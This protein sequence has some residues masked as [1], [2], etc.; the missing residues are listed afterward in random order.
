MRQLVLLGS[1]IAAG[2]LLAIALVMGLSA[3]I[4]WTVYLVLAP[5]AFAGLFFA[6]APWMRVAALFVP[7]IFLEHNIISLRP[8]GPLQ[9]GITLPVCLIL[10][11]SLRRFGPPLPTL[12][13]FVVLWLVFLGAAAATGFLGDSDPDVQRLR[14]QTIYLEG[15]LWFLLG[16]HTFTS[17]RVLSGLASVMV[18]CSLALAALHFRYLIVGTTLISPMPDGDLAGLEWR[19]GGPFGNPNSLADFHVM[20]L[21]AALTIAMISRRLWTRLVAGGAAIIACVA[22]L[23]T[24]SRGGAIAATVVTS[25][26]FGAM[27]LR[28]NRTVLAVTLTTLALPVAIYGATTFFPSAYELSMDRWQ[29]KGLEDVRP[30]IWATTVQIIGD[31]PLGLGHSPADYT[32]AL[33]SREPTLFWATPHN[34]FLGLAVSTGLIG[35][36]AFMGIALR[37]LR[38][39][40]QTI[41]RLDDKGEYALMVAPLLSVVGFLVAGFTEP[42]YDNGTKLNHILWLVLGAAVGAARGASAQRSAS[43]AVRLASLPPSLRP[44]GHNSPTRLA[45]AALSTRMGPP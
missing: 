1:V 2:V 30:E 38:E 41:R 29:E 37:A 27:L 16:A 28:S 12:R 40:W 3:S 34:I 36:F 15:F 6:R 10:F 31:N 26:T 33:A 44:T 32:A 25:L 18:F 20:S 43:E 19:Y 35:L 23:L 39:G 11:M 24:G 9:V 22:I 42:I 4:R 17:P 21:P 45:Q 8:V 14:V 5:F 7:L 13:G